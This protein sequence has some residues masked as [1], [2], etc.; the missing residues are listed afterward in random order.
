[1]PGPLIA[2]K[3]CQRDLRR[4][5]HWV[6]RETWGRD[7]VRR[8]EL[9]FFVGGDIPADA[10]EPDEQRLDCPDDYDSLPHKTRAICDYFLGSEKK[11]LFLCDTDTFLI[12]ERL[13]ATEHTRYDYSGRFGTIHP[14][15]TTFEYNDGRGI[16][17]NCHPYASGGIGYFL[18]RRAAFLVA[19]AEPSHWAEDLWVGQ[20]LGPHIQ[21]GEISAGDLFEF[22]C[23][24]SWHFP[25]RRFQTGYD[26]KY[27]W[28]EQMYQ[29]HCS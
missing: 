4:G 15:G 22:E 6:I 11:T 19:E 23:N 2:V 29:E 24:V 9:R 26:P 7:A 16:V 5:D 3:S 17:A 28:M 14:I 18:S 10:F 12:P 20:V 21:T 27:G 1:M 8:G 25:R 13:V